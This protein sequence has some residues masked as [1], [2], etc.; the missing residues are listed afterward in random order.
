MFPFSAVCFARLASLGATWYATRVR[1]FL[2]ANGGII[3]DILTG[4]VGHVG[5]SGSVKKNRGA[6]PIKKTVGT[7]RFFEW[8]NLGGGAKSAKGKK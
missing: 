3:L 6:V 1:G 8:G 2:G 5:G 7:R 4:R